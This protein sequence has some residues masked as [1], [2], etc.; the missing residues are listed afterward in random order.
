[1]KNIPAELCRIAGYVEGSH[2]LRRLTSIA[3]SVVHLNA[4]LDK[5]KVEGQIRADFVKLVT[6]FEADITD[7]K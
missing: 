5:F 2:G 7:K 6:S 4:T 1:M 3:A